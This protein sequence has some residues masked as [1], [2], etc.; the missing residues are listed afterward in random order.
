MAVFTYDTDLQMHTMEGCQMDKQFRADV[1]SS[2]SLHQVTPGRLL[3]P[4]M[5]P[6]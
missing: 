5:I 6:K 3:L 1:R 4:A 2:V